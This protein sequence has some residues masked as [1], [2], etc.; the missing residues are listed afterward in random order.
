M[1]MDDMEE[2]TAEQGMLPLL[3][4]AK[5]KLGMMQG[6]YLPTVQNILGVIFYIRFT[7]IVGIAGI[8]QGKSEQ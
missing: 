8:G 1:E 5:V 4:K 2:L 7:W 6:V 3:R